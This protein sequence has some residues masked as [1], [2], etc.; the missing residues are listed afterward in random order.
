VPAP[1][2]EVLDDAAT[3]IMPDDPASLPQL[4]ELVATLES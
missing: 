3:R 4:R 1:D 2:I